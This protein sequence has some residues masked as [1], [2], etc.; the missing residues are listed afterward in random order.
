MEKMNGKQLSFTFGQL[1]GLWH[2]CRNA[3]QWRALASDARFN[4]LLD[5]LAAAA[6]VAKCAFG[7]CTAALTWSMVCRMV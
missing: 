5:R 1:A 2:N 4:Y 6:R 7:V 3:R